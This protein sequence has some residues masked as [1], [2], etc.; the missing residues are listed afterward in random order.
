M[1]LGLILVVIGQVVRSAAMVQAGPSFN[2]IV[3]QTQKQEHILVTTGIYGK[4][5]H[6]SYFGFFWWGLGTQLVMGNVVCFVAYAAVL[7]KFFSARI[8]H[9]EIF[10]VKF[11]GGEYLDYR[12]NVGTKIPF[13][14]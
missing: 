10:L 13:V 3:Q 2:H 4:L 14:P 12:T 9:E 6:P 5:R 1:L 7:W 11:F 8:R